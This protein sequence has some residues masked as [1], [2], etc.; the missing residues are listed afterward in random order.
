MLCGPLST[1]RPTTSWSPSNTAA[2]RSAGGLSA[3]L[4]RENGPGPGA[5]VEMATC[6][7]RPMG[8]YEHSTA[9]YR[10]RTIPTNAGVQGTQA[11]AVGS[12]VEVGNLPG[13]HP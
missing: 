4:T 5:R 1:S 10:Q 7:S 12:Y 9:P 8:T 3:G 11:G 13:H 2:S 6:I